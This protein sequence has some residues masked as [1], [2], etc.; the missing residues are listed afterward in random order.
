L[1]KKLKELPY[2]DC[3]EGRWDATGAYL[4]SD[5]TP[6]DIEGWSVINESHFM[7]EES[8]MDNFFF[9]LQLSVCLFLRIS[10]YAGTHR[11]ILVPFI[12]IFRIHII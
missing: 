6:L 1:K 10:W 3:T 7:K 2:S 9:F 8:N 12:P 5:I 11:D 4:V